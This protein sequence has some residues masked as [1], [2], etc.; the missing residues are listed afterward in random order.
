MLKKSFLEKLKKSLLEQKKQLQAKSYNDVIDFEGDEIDEIQGKLIAN[1]SDQ[2]SSRDRQKL[3]QIEIALKKIA[4][5]SFGVCEDCDDPIA[6][7]RLEINPYFATCISCA[8]QREL[9]RKKL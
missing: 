3:L 8:E 9:E 2:L 7:K 1:V 6:E 5:K 4:D